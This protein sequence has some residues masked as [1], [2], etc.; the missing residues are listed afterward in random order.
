MNKLGDMESMAVSLLLHVV[1]LLALYFNQNP[2][3]VLV[4]DVCVTAAFSLSYSSLNIHFSKA[5]SKASSSVILGK[6]IIFVIALTLCYCRFDYAPLELSVWL[7][8]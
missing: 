1:S 3:L 2:W 4:I 7:S 6:T 5:A 8:N